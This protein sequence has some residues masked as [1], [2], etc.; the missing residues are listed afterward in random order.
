MPPDQLLAQAQASPQ[1]QWVPQ[2][3]WGLQAQA[4]CSAGF[5]Q[6]QVQPEL[7]QELQCAVP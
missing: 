1:R 3:H 4:R 5:W 7:G 6:P 2:A